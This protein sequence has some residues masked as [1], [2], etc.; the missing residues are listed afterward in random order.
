MPFT[1][2]DKDWAIKHAKADKAWAL[3]PKETGKKYGEDI[4]VLHPDTGYTNHPELIEGNRVST[5]RTLDRCF[6]GKFS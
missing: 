4:Y 3:T 1:D 6:F 2:S 5:G